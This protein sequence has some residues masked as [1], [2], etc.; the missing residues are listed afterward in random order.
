MYLFDSSDK[1]KKRFRRL[2][3]V[4]FDYPNF[5]EVILIEPATNLSLK[6]SAFSFFLLQTREY[7]L[8]ENNDPVWYSQ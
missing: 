8:T 1:K 3:V 7:T 2:T 6:N 5:T 4:I